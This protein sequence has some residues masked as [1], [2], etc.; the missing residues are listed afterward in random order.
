MP[1]APSDVPLVL[2]TSHIGGIGASSASCIDSPGT[3]VPWGTTAGCKELEGTM[4]G[5]PTL[6]ANDTARGKY[7]GV[8]RPIAGRRMIGVVEVQLL[9]PRNHLLSLR[10]KTGVA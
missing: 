5:S 3:N 2:S 9:P 4:A 10:T 6:A 1:I 8:T 7:R